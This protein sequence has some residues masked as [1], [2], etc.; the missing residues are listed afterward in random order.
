MDKEL[1]TVE[2]PLSLKEY[3]EDQHLIHESNWGAGGM[4]SEKFVFEYQGDL[5]VKQITYSEEDEIA[6]TESYEYAEDGKLHRTIIEYFD[7]SKDIITHKYNAE[8]NRISSH[9]VDEEG[10][11]GQQEFWEYQQNN[12]I[13]YRLI[14]DFGEVEEEQKMEY[15]DNKLIKKDYFNALEEIRQQTKYE[16]NQEGNLI[17]ESV[18]NTKGKLI[19]EKT[20]RYNEFGKI[21][22]E[23]IENA[24]ETNTKQI[25]YDK[26]GN[27]IYSIER[28]EDADITKYE[29][30]R[31]FDSNNNQMQSKV[32][33]YG[34]ED[35]SDLEYEVKYLYEF[36]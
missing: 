26:A 15:A 19:E 6:E 2:S 24:K 1:K 14:N 11:E 30:W 4:L 8:G 3:D 16:Y 25:Q 31:E 7:G 23:Q 21:V 9:T 13:L 33:I 35:H 5:L 12:L 22:F 20:Y 28:E 36:Y 10:D 34:N 32:L 18:F 17:K 29:V 27:E